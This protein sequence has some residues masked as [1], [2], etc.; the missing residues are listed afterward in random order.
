MAEPD[1]VIMYL[2]A[3][4]GWVAGVIGGTIGM[5]YRFLQ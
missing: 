1:G 2:A 5:L 3:K 4:A